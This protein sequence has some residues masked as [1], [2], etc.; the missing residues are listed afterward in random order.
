VEQHLYRRPPQHQGKVDGRFP[1]APAIVPCSKTDLGQLARS[2]V[3]P[4]VSP[5][6]DIPFPSQA[7]SHF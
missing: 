6:L 7:T 4:E 5:T 2:P 1:C 3:V